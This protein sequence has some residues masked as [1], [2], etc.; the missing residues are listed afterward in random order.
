[1]IGLRLY[2]LVWY[3]ALP[4][5]LARLVWRSVKAPGYRQHIPERL[6][7]IAPIKTTKPCLWI[8]AVSLGESI[9]AT[10]LIKSLIHS[11]AF[12]LLITNTTPTGRARIAQEFGT[13]V[14]QAW[15]PYDIPS[16]VERFISRAN[17][18][19]LI[20]METELWPNWL[21]ICRQKQIPSLLANGRLSATSASGYQRFAKLSATMMRDINRLTV[22]TDA[23]A[24]RFEQLGAK[25]DKIQVVGNIKFDINL[26]SAIASKAQA[27]R[28]TLAGRPCF[29][30]GSTHAGEDDII[31]AAFSQI[32]QKLPQA[33]LILVPRHPERFDTVAALIQAKGFSLARRSQ[34]HLPRA[35][36]QVLL[37]DTLGELTLLYGLADA[38]FIGGSLIPRG[39][40]NMLE[41]A[42]WAIPLATGPHMENFQQLHEELS[43]CGALT[44]LH[45]ADELAEFFLHCYLDPAQAKQLGQAGFVYLVKNQGALAR[46]LAEITHLVNH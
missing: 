42:L 46:I 29:I 5:I 13:Q 12:H 20:I 43:Q 3:I 4:F 45:T 9:A 27:T 36:Q 33:L 24:E 35:E 22:Q 14:S 25:R 6:G 8:H 10:P 17:P 23:H 31:L 38:A 11:N 37:G 28:S 18:C 34:D 40:H 26:D 39:G 21:N 7:F 15:A 16:C 32:I 1:M 44:T 41:A 30:A 2:T 19:A